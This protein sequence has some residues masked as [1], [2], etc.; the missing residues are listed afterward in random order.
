MPVTDAI[1]TLT[2]PGGPFE[3]VVEDV[4]GVPLQVYQ[5][6]LGSMRDLVLGADARGDVDWVVQGDRRLT[7]AEHNALVRRSRD[8]HCSTSAS[9]PATGSRCCRRTTSSGS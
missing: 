6:R 4:L 5:S 2:G 8:A 1:A 9:A 7:Y 3:I